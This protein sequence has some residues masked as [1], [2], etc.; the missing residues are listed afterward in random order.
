MRQKSLNLSYLSNYFGFVDCEFSNVIECITFELYSDVWRPDFTSSILVHFW[1]LVWFC[2][3]DGSYFFYYDT[4]PMVIT[5]R[6]VV[7]TGPSKQYKRFMKWKGRNTMVSL[8]LMASMFLSY[9]L[10]SGALFIKLCRI[11]WLRISQ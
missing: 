11:H 9:L 6:Q 2:F 8:H 5:H 1:L 7:F 4:L 3:L 10:P